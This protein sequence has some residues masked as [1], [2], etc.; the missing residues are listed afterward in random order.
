MNYYT[1]IKRPIFKKLLIFY[2]NFLLQRQKYKN[3]LNLNLN[4]MQFFN[5]ILFIMK[6]LII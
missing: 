2:F 3:L 6:K 5:E 4:F 1:N